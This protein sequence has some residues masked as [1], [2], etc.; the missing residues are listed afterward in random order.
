MLL[1]S[2]PH[3]HVLLDFVSVCSRLHL[4]PPH[5]PIPPHPPSPHS[6]LHDLYA[7]LAAVEAGAEQ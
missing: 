5:I 6:M 3:L 1:C 2:R 7:D 4:S